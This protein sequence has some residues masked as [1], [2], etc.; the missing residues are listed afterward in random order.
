MLILVCG[1][2]GGGK[3]TLIEYLHD[4]LFYNVIDIYVYRGRNLRAS[5]R[6]KPIYNENLKTIFT[7]KYIYDDSSYYIN[8]P[9]LKDLEKSVYLLD[10]PGEYPSCPELKG[11]E[12]LGILVLPPNQKTLVKRLNNSNRSYRI[13]SAIA[14]YAECLEDIKKELFTPSKWQVY[15]SYNNRSLVQFAHSISFHLSS[16]NEIL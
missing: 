8:L 1:P 9:T 11:I 4:N 14:E 5:E 7:N 2:S 12:W 13:K 15:L 3:T 16:K 6:F 10:Y